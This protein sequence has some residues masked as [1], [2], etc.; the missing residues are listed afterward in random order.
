MITKPRLILAAAFALRAAITA[1]MLHV[2][3]LASTACG[4]DAQFAKP[5]ACD[6]YLEFFAWVFV[7]VII[8]GG[9]RM[10]KRL[11]VRLGITFD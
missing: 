1:A 4:T 5:P 6:W 9:A 11:A 3:G 2:A 10:M 8:I 7:A